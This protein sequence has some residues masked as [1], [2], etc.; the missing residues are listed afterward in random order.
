[1]GMVKDVADR[2]IVFEKA[3]LVFDG[4]PEEGIDFYNDMM[5]QFTK[6]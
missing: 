4:R 3:K 5:A 2:V 6:Y 1:M